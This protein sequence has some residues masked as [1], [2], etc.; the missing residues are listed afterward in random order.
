[1]LTKK[2]PH[3]LLTLL[4][5]ILV[6][7]GSTNPLADEAQSNIESQNFEE[8]LAAAEKSIEQNPQ[9]PLGYYYKGVALGEMAG[10]EE[11]PEAR[12]E[13]YKEMNAAFAEAKEVAETAEDV[14]GEVER[15]DAVKNVLWQTE[16]NRAV[17]LATDDSLKQAVSN[18]LEQS[19]YHLKN[20]TNIQ[21]DSLL[22]WD[23]L[24][25]VAAMNQSFEEA[26][27]A[28]EKFISMAQDTSLEAND[29]LQ[30]ASY[31][32]QL[33]NQQEVVNSLEKAHE[34]FPDN[35]E[36]VS[37]LADAYQRVGEPE[38]A[39]ST[40]EKLVE[41][42]PENPQ[43]HLVLGTQIY[44]QALTITDSLSANSNEIVKLRQDL[45][46]S[47]DSEKQDIQQ[48]I[49]NLQQENQQLQSKIDELTDRAE[50]ELNTVLEY[51]PNDDAAYNTLGII[52][53]NK[54]KALFDQRNQTTDNQ[55]AA[56][57]DKQGQKFLK[58]AMNNYERAAEIDP[59]NQEYWK[60]LFSIYTALG[61]DEKAQE[62]M[63]KAGMQ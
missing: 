37:N 4:I 49:E 9:D 21:P 29:Y 41:Q 30:L 42:E 22:S 53:Q 60:S 54:A 32:F 38:K 62:A 61:M 10:A 52:Y 17:E 12:A 14:P 57:L 18:P 45:N 1:M 58:E 59:N 15:I 44:Q 26:A 13:T 24:S 11:D 27:N 55:K 35:Q 46:N 63:K 25:Q 50:E 16:H 3:V 43:Y 8:A 5:G 33:D 20:A 36:I 23:V 7:C 2:L 48:Q 39:I 56:E 51:R 40:V 47:S 6:G 19:M 34:Q 31:H 28:K